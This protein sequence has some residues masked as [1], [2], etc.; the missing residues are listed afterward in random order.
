M[1]ELKILLEELT[2][3][4]RVRVRRPD[5]SSA[6]GVA[7]NKIRAVYGPFKDNITIKQLSDVPSI[8]RWLG[9]SKMITDDTVNMF[10]LSLVLVNFIYV[11]ICVY[12]CILYYMTQL[13]MF[14]TEC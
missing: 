14:L 13:L 7:W 3:D 9:R 2:R 4:G 10:N 1:K 8:A 5:A 6:A 11:A 12:F